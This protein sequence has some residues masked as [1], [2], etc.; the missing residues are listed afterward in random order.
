MLSKDRGDRLIEFGGTRPRHGQR[1]NPI[2]RLGHDP[3]SVAHQADFPRTFQLD[4]GTL[5]VESQHGFCPFS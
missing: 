3:S 5:F 2:E 1:F 4:D